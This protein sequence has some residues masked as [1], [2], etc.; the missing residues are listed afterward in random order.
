MKT[1]KDMVLLMFPKK[2][3]RKRITSF[4]KIFSIS[5]KKLPSSLKIEL[6]K[7]GIS[8]HQINLTKRKKKWPFN[9]L[10]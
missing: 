1:G 6:L 7:L 9:L 2:K 4:L 5:P 10:N 8:Q 3:F